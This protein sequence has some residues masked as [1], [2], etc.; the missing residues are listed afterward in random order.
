MNL[1][2][3]AIKAALF[4]KI[5]VPAIGL[6]TAFF[7][8][9]FLPVFMV[10]GAGTSDG[11]TGDVHFTGVGISDSVPEEYRADVLR[12]G[13]ICPD[14]TPAIIAARNRSRIQLEPGRNQPRRRRRNRTI[15]AR[16]LG[17]ERP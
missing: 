7:A 10:G 13:T 17:H 4:W 11:N 14:V 6:A 8:L 3:R 5:G 9:I 12:A 16:H 2:K 1:A 15:H